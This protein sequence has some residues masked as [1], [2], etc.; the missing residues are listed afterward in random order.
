M[1]SHFEQK[2]NRAVSKHFIFACILS[3]FCCFFIQQM[4][5]ARINGGDLIILDNPQE[6]K[7][8]S[9]SFAVFKQD[10]NILS[11]AQFAQSIRF[12]PY[13]RF[14][15]AN[16]GF[17]TNGVWLHATVL[18]KT[19][20][21]RWVLSIRFSKLQEAEVY[22]RASGEVIYEGNDGNVNKQG[23]FALPSFNIPL[24]QNEEVD[25][26]VF[27]RSN[28]MSLM[29][30]IYLQSLTE[31][32]TASMLDFGIWGVFYGALAVLALYTITFIGY[33]PSLISAIFLAHLF[34]VFAFEILWSG[35]NSFSLVWISS[36]YEYIRAESLIL[37]YIITSTLFTLALVPAA[38]HN[39]RLSNIMYGVVIISAS[40]F[41]L[42][43]I[44][45]VPIEFKLI[46]TYALGFTN[47]VAN[48]ILTIQA[49]LAGFFP[50]RPVLVGWSLLLLGAMVNAAFIFGLIAPP[51]YFTHLFQLIL[52]LQCIV[53][54]LGIALK[55]Q[56]DLRLEV[57][58]AQ[59]DSENNFS[60][61]EEQN[62]HL[63]IARKAA[64]KA[65]VV[66][67]QFL[68]NM[69]H[70]VRTP[71]NAIIGFSKELESKQNIVESDE[72]V[73]IINSA[74]SDL[75]TIVN[76]ILDFSKMEAGKLVLNVRPFSPRDMLEEVV[77][78][79][80]KSAHLKQL[81]FIF[82]VGD[83]PASVLGDGFKLK[84]LLSNLLSNALKFTN[85]GYISLKAQLIESDTKECEIEFEVHD[86]GIGISPEDVAKIFTAFHQ[87]DDELNRSFQGTGLGLV[88]CQELTNLMNG[89]IL[90]DS[91]PNK[92]SVF[93]ARIP[94]KIDR[95][96]TSIKKDQPFANQHATLIDEWPDSQLA[97][98]KQ[99]AISGFKVDAF[100]STKGIEHLN[101]SKDFVFVC[102]PFRSNENRNQKIEQ[103]SKLST[104]N[105]VLLYS[106]PSPNSSQ[107][108]KF[109]RLPHLIR[110]PLTTQKLRDIQSKSKT[111]IK[112]N[113]SSKL[114]NLP[115]I[116]MLAVDDI[117][118]NLRLL[119][120]WMAPSPV[121]LDLAYDGKTAIKYCE[122]QEYDLILMDIQM[123]HM[124]GLE[125]TS[126]IRKSEL[127]MGTPII[128]I[129][130]HALASEKQHFLDSGMDDFLAKPILLDS[131]LAA[132]KSWCKQTPQ[133]SAAAPESIDWELALQ[134]SYGN[135][136]SAISF[137]DTFVDRLR[138]HA[139]EIESGWQ[140]QRVD[141]VLASIHKLHGACC[142]TGVPRLQEYCN[143][144]ET[145]LKTDTLESHSKTLST[146][147]LEIEQV[148]ANW[149][150]RREILSN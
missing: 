43:L 8:I 119:E 129:T 32:K 31:N 108:S 26:F 131:L 132:I 133:Q 39:R 124:D 150:K 145:R 24:P 128:A 70:E 79:M 140:Q 139:D 35:Q 112:S 114:S 42:F 103:L 59:A 96:S 9:N 120:T 66:K 19:E 38:L 72:H 37:I 47:I 142:Y 136:D 138:E 6:T 146:L 125:T 3:L 117:D 2:H 113:A 88:I 85:Y 106:G 56:Y 105:L 58:E 41:V 65:S 76:D 51:P 135:K 118:L 86:T 16:Y 109:A 29:A 4:A 75:L 87:L 18:N 12:L 97:T 93:S 69:S 81:E 55:N 78:L 115:P 82:D 63:D 107:L 123:P 57:K 122:K 22:V 46:V 33:R 49:Y 28:N 141:L 62:V 71:L 149:P 61:I 52:V 130:A 53:F 73:R 134:R 25:V 13:R 92:G 94:F 98:S 60:L 5:H 90:V 64:V 147:L 95:S 17:V 121:T 54:L 99:L 127:N 102:L 21:P 15:D 40:C 23:P 80:A 110:L 104:S 36:I 91:E 20:L 44:P 67:S 10:S 144:T 34:T 116:R 30:P 1:V 126:Y 45:F 14:D 84:Q 111:G 74:A 27:L 137:L 11:F 7:L 100:K 148:E 68:A 48:V 89:T 143:D 77:A 101:L 83:L 50:A